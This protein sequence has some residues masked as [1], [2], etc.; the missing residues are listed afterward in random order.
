MAELS[1]HDIANLRASGQELTV[2]FQ[3]GKSGLTEGVVKELQTHLAREPLVK[4]KLL[5]SAFGDTDK[6]ALA[7]ELAKQARVILVEIRG[8]TALYYRLPRHK[9]G[10][11][12]F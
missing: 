4:V 7:E 3:I 12:D 8:N 2:S 9:R 11:E 10:P 1:P 6:R 5:K